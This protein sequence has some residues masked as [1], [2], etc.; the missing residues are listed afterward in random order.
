MYKS[1]SEV[2][3]DFKQSYGEWGHVLQKVHVGLN[4]DH[5][6][7]STNPVCWRCCTISPE[8]KVWEDVC[9]TFNDYASKVQQLQDKFRLSGVIPEFAEKCY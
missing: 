4:A 6:P 2:I 9:N 7:Y 5:N 8:D 1:L 3:T